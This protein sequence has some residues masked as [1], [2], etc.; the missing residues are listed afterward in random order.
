MTA[1]VMNWKQEGAEWRL[2]HNRR[3]VGRVTPDAK[4]PG[5]WRI[6]LPGGWSDMVNL[7]RAKDA[8]LAPAIRRIEHT[9][10]WC[11][12]RGNS[13]T[14]SRAIFAPIITHSLKSVGG[15]GGRYPPPPKEILMPKRRLFPTPPDP[16]ELDR[17]RAGGELFG[18]ALGAAFNKPSHQR[19][20]LSAGPSR[21]RSVQRNARNRDAG[22]YGLTRPERPPPRGARKRRPKRDE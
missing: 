20:P 5:M 21:H 16:A 7:T 17:A 8:A 6:K 2:L 10:E 13:S 18:K 11:R 9:P 3:I 4:Y 12:I 1:P 19:Q 14:K 15:T 22:L